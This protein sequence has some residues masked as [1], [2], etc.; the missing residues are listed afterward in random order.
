MIRIATVLIVLLLTQPSFAQ[1]N[2][3]AMPS[4][5]LDE[6]VGAY[7]T[8]SG[9]RV[10]L[11]PRVKGRARIIGQSINDLSYENLATVLHLHN[12]AT[13]RSNG[14]LIVVPSNIIKQLAI[15]LVTEGEQYAENQYVRDL[16]PVDKICLY[17][18]MPILRPLVAPTSHFAPIANPRSILMTGTYANTQRIREIIASLDG[19]LDKQQDCKGWGEDSKGD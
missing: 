16:I 9:E 4:I 19:K 17:A 12:F 7:S 11:D 3:T 6:L 10:L 5:D 8:K 13:Y 14:Y 15:D 18:L 2:N 1:F